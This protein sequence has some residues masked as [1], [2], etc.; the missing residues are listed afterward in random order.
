MNHELNDT[1]VIK[2]DNTADW[3]LRAIRDDEAERDR[4]IAIA[5]NQIEE[6]KA[7]I[8]DIKEKYGRKTAFLRGHLAMYMNDVPNKETKTQRTYQL[9]TGKLIMKKPSQKMVP[10]DE[11]LVKYLETE[12]CPE[13]I[14]VVQKPDWAEFKKILAIMDGDVVNTMTGEV[15]APEIIAIE[16]VPASFDVKFNK[17]EE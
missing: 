5:N 4:L 17:E 3:A 2:D 16:D 12:K 13:L 6:L 8:E 14:K 7:Q 11:A 10:N 9:L 1:F 15:I